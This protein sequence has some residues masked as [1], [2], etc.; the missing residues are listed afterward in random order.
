MTEAMAVVRQDR[1]SSR[2]LRMKMLREELEVQ[3]WTIGAKWDRF[4]DNH[5]YL[6]CEGLKSCDLRRREPVGNRLDQESLMVRVLRKRLM[7][8][9]MER[10]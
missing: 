4:Q 1:A 6:G 10:A 3:T 7:E 2:S 9:P 5:N 8:R